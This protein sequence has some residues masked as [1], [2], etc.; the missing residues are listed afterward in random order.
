MTHPVHPRVLARYRKLLDTHRSIL[1]PGEL[2]AERQ[3]QALDPHGLLSMAEE[4]GGE[5]AARVLRVRVEAARP[6][7]DPQTPLTSGQTKP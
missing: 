2:T 1:P 5:R 4:I 6:P 3:I 7:N